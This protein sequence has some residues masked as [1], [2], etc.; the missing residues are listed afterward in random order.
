LTNLSKLQIKLS[1]RIPAGFVGKPQNILNY[2]T[3]A[4]R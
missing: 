3:V 2:I 4:T 1:E